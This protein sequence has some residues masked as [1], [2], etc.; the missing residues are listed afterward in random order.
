MNFPS[1]NMGLLSV[2]R[3]ALFKYDP[4][5]DDPFW[6]VTNI[7]VDYPDGSKFDTK[8]NAAFGLAIASWVLA[9]LAFVAI[10]CGGCKP[11]IRSK[12]KPLGCIMLLVALFQGLTLLIHSS[13]GCDAN[14]NPVFLE[15][16][17][18]HTYYVDECS[19]SRGSRMN[20]ASVVM[21]FLAML[22]LLA[23]PPAENEGEV[24]TAGEDIEAGGEEVEV[25]EQAVEQE[26]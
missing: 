17:N 11:E 16:P 1:L 26:K 9:G 8:W 14:K 6:G 2:R 13:D 18:L 25:E 3:Q 21:Y 4:I 15:F 19:L 24:F 12:A 23:T 5:F 22:A 10:S 7:C 20:I